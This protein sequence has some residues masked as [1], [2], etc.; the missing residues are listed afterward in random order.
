MR[1]NTSAPSIASPIFWKPFLNS[2]ENNCDGV[3]FSE[4]VS[5]EVTEER[6]L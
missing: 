3:L 6:N 4:F 2:S 5:C 1:T